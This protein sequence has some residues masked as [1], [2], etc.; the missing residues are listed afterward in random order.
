MKHAGT[1]LRAFAHCRDPCGHHYASRYC[2]PFSS[3]LASGSR[4]DLAKP[5]LFV[6]D[7]QGCTHPRNSS[8]LTPVFGGDVGAI[9]WVRGRE[10]GFAERVD[11]REVRRRYNP[12]KV[13]RGPLRRDRHDRLDGHARLRAYRAHPG[14][15]SAP[16]TRAGQ[17]FPFAPG[18]SP[19]D[20]QG[21]HG[22]QG[23]V[24]GIRLRLSQ[25]VPGGG[26]AKPGR[27]NDRRQ[28]R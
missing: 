15:R 19:T 28:R 9:S 22:R 13:S 14:Y 27:A 1:L 3:F 7:H 16:A 20:Y 8:W 5:R 4:R 23:Y 26:C 25:K 17:D 6:E 2:A 11:K 10:D 24:S 18:P 12:S 21:E